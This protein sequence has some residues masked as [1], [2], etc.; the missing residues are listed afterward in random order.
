MNNSSRNLIS[1]S[2]IFTSFVESQTTLGRWKLSLYILWKRLA[3]NVCVSYTSK[4]K[5]CI[6]IVASILGLMILAPLFFVL[7]LLI[8]WEDGGPVLFRQ[9]RVG[10]YGREFKMLKFRSMFVN[11]EERLKDILHQNQHKVG[12]TFKLKNDPRITKVGMF[13]RKWSLDE[14][15][16]L[17][18]VLRGDMSL[19]G[20]RPP[21]PREVSLYGLNER[22]R[23]EVT[24]GITCFWQISGR[25]NISFPLQ[26]KLDVQY[27]ESQ[28]LALDLKILIKTIP[29]VL[30]GNGAY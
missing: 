16:Q 12:V 29:A 25:S 30:S 2:K 24:P 18:N 5:R 15:P 3:W 21:I 4:I 22:K 17:L 7:A 11:A 13:L 6:D 20:P 8:K 9:I 10:K 23:L 14:L 26:V 1:G 27:I 28:S 19:V